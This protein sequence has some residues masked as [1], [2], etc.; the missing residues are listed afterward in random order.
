MSTRND[1]SQVSALSPTASALTLHTSASMPPSSLA[2]A[3]I[4][5]V[6][7]APSATSSA[8][9]NA[10]TPLDFNAATVAADLIGVAGADR[11]VGAL[12]GK[13]FGHCATD[14]LAATRDQCPLALEPEV[15]DA[16]LVGG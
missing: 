7:A 12:G 2:L 9:P 15:H 3:A 16:L 6:S 10:L 1:F 4:Q 14:A 11:D 5:P 13:A 8:R